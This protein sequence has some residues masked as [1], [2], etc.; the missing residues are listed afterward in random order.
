M[1]FTGLDVGVVILGGVLT[2]CVGVAIRRLSRRS[3]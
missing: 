1:P 3:G 2:L